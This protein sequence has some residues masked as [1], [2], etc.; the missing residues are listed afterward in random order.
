MSF[1]KFR[2]PIAF[3]IGLL[4]FTA[5]VWYLLRYFQWADI[6]SQL[7][8]VDFVRVVVLVGITHFGYI[9]LRAWRW[10][11]AI[12][13]ANPHMSFLDQ[14][15]ITAIVVSLAIVT[16]GQ[17]GETLKIELLKR[18]H[19]V[20]RMPGLDAF[21]L[22]RLLDLLTISVIGIIGL[23]AASGKTRTHTMIGVVAVVLIGLATIG[24]IVLLRLDPGGRASGWLTSIRVG[25]GKPAGW[26]LM[27]LLTIGS[28]SLVAVGW[29]I[30][31]G[32]VQVRV[33]FPQML[34][35]MS[36]VTLGVVLSFIPGGVGVSEALAAT[37]LISMGVAPVSAQVAAL[38]LRAHALIVIV[39]GLIHLGLW[40]LYSVFQDI[41]EAT[42]ASRV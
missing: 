23:M 5:S 26:A 10:R 31:F 8:R 30:V 17:L 38:M 24:L 6:L 15:W 37:S 25:T 7:R 34:A 9:L 33:S 2:S 27:A 21:V 12:R 36:F 13:H 14:Y 20:D 22:E 19:L 41:R 35:L 18:R 40:S 29:Q 28:W 16:P 3:S 4:A 39:F 11:V 1:Q 42:P 32:A